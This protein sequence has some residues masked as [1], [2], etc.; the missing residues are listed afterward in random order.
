MEQRYETCGDWW[1]EYINISATEIKLLLQIRV[2]DMKNP[3]YEY[4]VASHELD[5]AMLCL[6]RGIKEKAISNYDKAFEALR[7]KFPEIIGDQEPGDMI[8]APYF[9]EHQFAT[10]LE[11]YRV[12]E[13]GFDWNEYDKTI[14]EL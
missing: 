11:K 2:S 12:K 5:E 13:F 9:E 6:S 7:L 1:F 3:F 14:G 10:K 4:F 8:A